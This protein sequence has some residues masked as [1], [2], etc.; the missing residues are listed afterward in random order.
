MPDQMPRARVHLWN[1]RS[2]RDV[3]G[4]ALFGIIGIY[5]VVEAR[6]Y[7]L[8]TLSRMKPGMFPLLL[9]CILIGL[10]CGEPAGSNRRLD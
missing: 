4:G 5:V 9:G 1:H 7:G 3:V 6:Q 2:L 10:G 8:G